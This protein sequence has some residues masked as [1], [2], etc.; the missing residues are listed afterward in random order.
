[1]IDTHLT[2]SIINVSDDDMLL[3]TSLPPTTLLPTTP[4]QP[5]PKRVNY[6]MYIL[7]SIGAVASIFIF[8][9]IVGV[10]IEILKLWGVIPSIITGY[11]DTFVDQANTRIESEVN[12]VVE[13]II[14]GVSTTVNNDIYNVLIPNLEHRFTIM[15]NSTVGGITEL[16]KTIV[17]IE[18]LT[19]YACK[20]NPQVCI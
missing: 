17:N 16:E 3:T 10:A 2:A 15:L 1:M 12:N 9:T 5:P 8:A 20:L 19:A 7:W 14:N 18:Q 4:L 6:A 13:K 11:A